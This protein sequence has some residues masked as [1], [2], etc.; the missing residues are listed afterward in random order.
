MDCRNC[1][2]E[3]Q[4]SKCKG[5]PMKWYK[6][7][8]YFG[9]PLSALYAFFCSFVY[10]LGG[11]FV[12]NGRGT[13]ELYLLFEPFNPI[14]IF[15]GIIEL[16]LAVFIVITWRKL[17]KLS[18]TGPKCHIAIFIINISLFMAYEILTPFM[19]HIDIS[20]AVNEMLTVIPRTI[21]NS[22]PSVIGL[23][24]HVIYYKKR[25]HLFH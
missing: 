17:L 3:T 18:V 10:F 22:I 19:L 8:V 21:L 23:L 20:N 7:C 24:L 12:S 11:K 1:N 2:R 5:M 15:F 9:L 13:S 4:E 25:K 16:A 6:F 14:A